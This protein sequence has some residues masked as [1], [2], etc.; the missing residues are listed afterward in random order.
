[1]QRNPSYL[2]QATLWQKSKFIAA[3]VA[4]AVSAKH[5]LMQKEINCSK[6]LAKLESNNNEELVTNWLKKICMK[7][8]KDRPLMSVKIHDKSLPFDNFFSNSAHNWRLSPLVHRTRKNHLPIEVKQVIASIISD[9]DFSRASLPLLEKE[10][11]Q[12]HSDIRAPMH[13]A[14]FMIT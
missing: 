7:N 14:Y 1:M 2:C 4:G 9:P 12:R 10:P 5:F 8:C 6:L 13:G 3:S 11:Q